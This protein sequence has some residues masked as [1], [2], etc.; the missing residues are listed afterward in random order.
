MNDDWQ[1]NCFLKKV[2]KAG[3]DVADAGRPVL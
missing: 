1:P 3:T 2:S